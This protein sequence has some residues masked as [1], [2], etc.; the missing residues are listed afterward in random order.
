VELSEDTSLRDLFMLSAVLAIDPTTGERVPFSWNY[1]S[2][3]QAKEISTADNMDLG[4]V[5]VH[6]LDGPEKILLVLSGPDLAPGESRLVSS[7]LWQY[8]I[9]GGDFARLQSQEASTWFGFF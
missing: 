2:P 3:Y 8:N 6:E 4:F 1:N 5:P 7:K 9:K